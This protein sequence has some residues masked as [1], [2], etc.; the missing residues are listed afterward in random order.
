[1]TR[2]TNDTRTA[3]SRRRI[4]RLV[5]AVGVGGIAAGGVGVVGAI[6]DSLDTDSD[7]LQEVIVVF[8]SSG[9]V[10]RLLDLNLEDELYQFETVP[11]G[12]TTL[13]GDQIQMVAS[14]PEVNRVAANEAL[15]WE[16][17][18]AREDTRAID[19]QAGDGLDVPYTGENVHVAVMDTGIDALHPDLEDNVEGHWQ[20]VGDPLTDPQGTI[21]LAAGDTNTDDNGHG[22]HCAGSIAGDGTQSDGEF[23]GM[24]PDASITAYSTNLSLTIVKAVAAYDHMMELQATGDHEIHIASNS[25]GAGP[26]EFDPYDPF[27]VAAWMAH[28]MGILTT[29]SAGNDGEECETDA[30]LLN[31]EEAHNTLGHRKHAPY[32][33]SVAATNADQSVA[34]FSS[35]GTKDRNHD[36]QTA[37]ENMVA[38]Y[39]GTPEEDI[40]GPLGIFRPA[41][42][43]KGSSVMSTLNPAHP[44][45]GLST[46][47]ET[48]YGRLSGT[49]MSNPVTAGCAALVIDAYIENVGEVPDPIDVINTL[50]AEADPDALADV[51]DLDGSEYTTERMGTGY[52]D[53]LAATARAEQGDLADFE[54]V[55]LVDD[56]ETETQTATH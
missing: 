14:W 47:T 56:A 39:S 42:G 29:F 40:E 24:A 32:V 20:W 50:E 31:C 43:A 16:N 48:W 6:D 45:Q 15:E 9:D 55:T 12:Y 44:L 30:G 3:L 28:E 41:V 36:R 25:W 2:S 51:D 34:S 46:D 13:T 5:G 52:V 19:V 26:G 37:Y 27:N 33:L 8:E 49:S 35:R 23:G 22:T 53:A 7:V 18:D 21:W 54:E 11:F 17:D 38:F 10:E 1:M 4:L